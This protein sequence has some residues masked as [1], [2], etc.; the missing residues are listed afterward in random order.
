MSIPVSVR[1]SKEIRNRLDFE[2]A[3]KGITVSRLLTEIINRHFQGSDNVAERVNR[4]LE[5]SLQVEGLLTVM[6]FWQQEV[7]AT[8]LG[9]TDES[10]LTRER[11]AEAVEKKSRA[12][13]ALQSM[14]DEAAKRTMEGGNAW[15]KVPG[16][17]DSPGES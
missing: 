11:L 6:M 1:L 5:E 14:L 16:E 13:T 10:P 7:F 3:Q 4:I 9:R 8:L 17:K 12:A 2:A 15:G